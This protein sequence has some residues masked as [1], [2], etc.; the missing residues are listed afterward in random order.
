MVRALGL[1]MAVVGLMACEE[2][3]GL[4]LGDTVGFADWSLV[5]PDHPMVDPATA[6]T[7]DAAVCIDRLGATSIGRANAHA[8]LLQ[9]NDLP[10]V[11]ITVT[12]RDI[13][14]GTD[15]DIWANPGMADL[16][17]TETVDPCLGGPLNATAGVCYH[18]SAGATDLWTISSCAA[19]GGD[20]RAEHAVIMLRESNYSGSNE[21]SGGVIAHE[22]GHITGGH[23]VSVGDGARAA[24]GQQVGDPD[25]VILGHRLLDIVHR[26]QPILQCEQVAQRFLGKFERDGLAREVSVCYH[27]MQRALQLADIRPEALADEETDFVGKLDAGLLRLA[28]EDRDAGLELGRLDG[29]GQ[30]PA[31]T[32]FQALFDPRDLLGVAVAGQHDLLLTFEQSIES[33]EE[34]FL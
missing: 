16:L 23:V 33:M 4:T 32:R 18:T 27:A 24:L 22:L 17:V 7:L 1:G 9:L 14:C 25:L 15:A 34:F 13:T 29:D 19:L 28:H 5:E 20:C 21:P 12:V 11:D 10:G 26:D 2:N 6:T 30:A 3:E 31:E 8:A